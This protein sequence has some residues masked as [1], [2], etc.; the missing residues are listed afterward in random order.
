[1]GNYHTP[2]RYH[3][4]KICAKPIPFIFLQPTSKPWNIFSPLWSPFSLSSSHPQFKLKRVLVPTLQPEMQ[5]S[6]FQNTSNPQLTTKSDGEEWP[7]RPLRKKRIKESGGLQ[8]KSNVKCQ[9]NSISSG[10]WQ[11]EKPQQALAGALAAALPH[12]SGARH[13]L[14]TP[15][16]PKWCQWG[17]NAPKSLRTHPTLVAPCKAGITALPALPIMSQ[18]PTPWPHE[19]QQRGRACV[20]QMDKA[21]SVYRIFPCGCKIKKWERNLGCIIVSWW[22]TLSAWPC[23]P[24]KALSF[25]PRRQAGL[26]WI[27]N[28]LQHNPIHREGYFWKKII[29]IFW[30]AAKNK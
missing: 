9:Q 20:P 1:M 2:I 21:H 13:R 19:Q 30:L 22:S 28:G 12:G 8:G 6:G 4:A 23:R 27:Q 14:P 7:R 17:R 10:P 5:R 29:F 25:Y 11:G 16:S 24:S 3:S 18:C 15:G 26:G